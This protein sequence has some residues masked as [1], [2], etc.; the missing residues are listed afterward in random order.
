MPNNYNYYCFKLV[1]VH[2][3]FNSK[4]F[5]CSLLGSYEPTSTGVFQQDDTSDLTYGELIFHPF[6]DTS[7]PESVSYRLNSCLW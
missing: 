4:H 3:D 1:C 6:V 2:C 7:T 5:C